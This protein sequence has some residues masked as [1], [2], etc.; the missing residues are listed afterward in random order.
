ML[1]EMNSDTTK[2][3][4]EEGSDLANP[5]ELP[6]LLEEGNTANS[7][8]DSLGPDD[9]FEETEDIATI[10]FRTQE[11]E[12]FTKAYKRSSTIGNIKME[13]STLFSIPTTQMAVS[14]DGKMLMDDDVLAN[15]GVPAMGIL[16]LGMQIEKPYSLNRDVIYGHIP[17][18]DVIVVRANGYDFIVEIENRCR[19]KEWLGGFRHKV[20]N[21][22]YHHAWTQTSSI[23]EGKLTS[24]T[25]TTYGLSKHTNTPK[26]KTTQTSSIP[27]LTDKVVE[28]GTYQ[29]YV[30]DEES[31]SPKPVTPEAH[32]ASSPEASPVGH[33]HLIT[34]FYFWKIET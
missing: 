25:Q 22:H 3:S 31:I 24:S 7:N 21:K 23:L 1:Y 33:I 16:E 29:P 28:V 6:E 14:N 17:N 20:T 10:K 18:I 8:E 34:F 9:F 32:F 13:L 2:Y 26:E 15:L 30:E 27:S 4:S 12:I 5:H 11:N 19:R